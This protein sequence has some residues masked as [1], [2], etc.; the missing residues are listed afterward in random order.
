MCLIVFAW[1]LLPHTPLIVASNRDEFYDRPAAPAIWWEGAPHVFGGRDLQSGGTWM[2]VANQE[3]QN[4]AAKKFAAIT[5]VRAPSE[6]R[7]DAPSRGTLVSN[8]LTG[9]LSAK[10]YIVSIK[11][12][13]AD[14]NGFNLLVGDEEDLIWFSNRK[15]DDPRNGQPLSPGIYGISNAA[16][17]TPWPKVVKTKAEFA[18]LLC[19]RAPEEAYFEML[20]NTTPAPD[21]RLPDTG[22]SFEMERLLSSPCIESPDYGTRVSSLI[23][24]H[25]H[26]PAEFHE[27]LLR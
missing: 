5:N 2:G 7:T 10:D 22:I 8:Y 26:H 19:Q 4:A 24:I 18:S 3:D 23:K 16:L 6:K 12:K 25:S 27:K 1:K 11:D 13:V 9:T 20:S 15:Q 14:Y 17:D 21:C